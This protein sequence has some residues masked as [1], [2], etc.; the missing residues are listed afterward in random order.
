MA[1]DSPAP[2]SRRAWLGQAALG[3]L[4]L[5]A[6]RRLPAAPPPAKPV[7]VVYKDPQCG[8]CTKW[9]DH[10][11]AAGFTLQVRDTADLATVKA[12]VGVPSRLQSCHTALIGGYFVEGHVPA[13]LVAKLLRE[14]PAIAGLA[15]PGMPAGSPGME[16]PPP[17]RY[18]VV[19]VGR[20]GRTSVY[21]VRVGGA[22]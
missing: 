3:A 21:A 22:A 5:V 19:A 9:N 20:D 17:E 2:L 10:M 4:A 18:E 1:P 12:S 13:D 14:K 11:K 8:C 15:V 7:M 6:A 16:G